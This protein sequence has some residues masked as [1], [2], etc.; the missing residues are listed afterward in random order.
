MAGP[1][2]PSNRV[3]THHKPCTVKWYG[4][5]RFL[6][7]LPSLIYRICLLSFYNYIWAKVS[8]W[9]PEVLDHKNTVDVKTLVVPYTYV[10]QLRQCTC[11]A[12]SEP[13]YTYP[14]H[15]QLV[16]Q[17][18]PNM[19]PV[20]LYPSQFTGLI[21]CIIAVVHRKYQACGLVLWRHATRY[22]CLC[23]RVGSAKSFLGQQ[24]SRM[25]AT[26]LLSHRVN[27]LQQEGLNTVFMRHFY[28]Q[29]CSLH[30]CLKVFWNG[31]SDQKSEVM[32]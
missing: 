3:S 18:H 29:A 6:L 7:I 27:E 9:K 2:H 23:V 22:T 11:Q 15:D 16:R 32:V 10:V 25:P 14:K 30:K 13:A 26:N 21:S 1:S 5:S 20:P 17:D 12:G 28:R 4:Q 8:Y 19:S 31:I 24:R